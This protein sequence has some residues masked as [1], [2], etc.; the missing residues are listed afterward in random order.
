MWTSWDPFW[1][2]FCV[3]LGAAHNL[4]L[5]NL[6]LEGGDSDSFRIT[7]IKNWK[8]KEIPNISMSCSVIC[9]SQEW[10]QKNSNLNISYLNLKCYLH[11]ATYYAVF[12]WPLIGACFCP[13]RQEYFF[14]CLPTNQSQFFTKSSIVWVRLSYWNSE[15]STDSQ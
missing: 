1:L 2:H 7:L 3:V 9:R 5:K 10:L 8:Q 11:R 14:Y 6:L 13:C 15:A 4:F 12:I